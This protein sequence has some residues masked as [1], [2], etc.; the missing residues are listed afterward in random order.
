MDLSGYDAYL[1]GKLTDYELPEEEM[2]KYLKDLE[3]L[4]K[5]ETR[6]TGKW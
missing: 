6:K 4:P 3:R 1:S 2:K 5:A